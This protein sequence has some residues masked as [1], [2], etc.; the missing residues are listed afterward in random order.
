MCLCSCQCWCLCQCLLHLCWYVKLSLCWFMCLGLWAWNGP[1]WDCHVKVVLS[2]DSPLVG[3]TLADPTF[4]EMYAATVCG[5][6]LWLNLNANNGDAG[7]S[8]TIGAGDNY[9]AI[10][11]IVTTDSDFQPVSEVGAGSARSCTESTSRE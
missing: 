4:A 7:A 6:R 5:L 1:T 2:H 8:D 3:K 9:D 10:D 11:V